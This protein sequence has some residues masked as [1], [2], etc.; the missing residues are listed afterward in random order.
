MFATLTNCRSE[1]HW[2]PEGSTIALSLESRLFA[3][4]LSEFALHFL[5]LCLWTIYFSLS[6]FFFI[7]KIGLIIPT[8]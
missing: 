8:S 4:I 7:S 1:T 5:V 2:F 3:L 6:L